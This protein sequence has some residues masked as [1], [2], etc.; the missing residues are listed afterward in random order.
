MLPEKLL[1]SMSLP[2]EKKK[3]KTTPRRSRTSK[4]RE[5]YIEGLSSL[6]SYHI[7]G[8]KVVDEKR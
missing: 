6:S 4:T 2:K 5:E 8:I 3:Q 1:V 7:E